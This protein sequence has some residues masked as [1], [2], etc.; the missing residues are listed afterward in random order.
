MI[1]RI[2]Y[3]LVK[4]DNYADANVDGLRGAG[5]DALGWYTYLIAGQDPAQQADILVRVIRAHGGLRQNEFVVCDVEEGS[6]DQSSR[7][8]AY[9]DEVDSGLQM[10]SP[11]GQEWWYSGLNFAI[12]HNLAAARG[13]RWIA[14]YGQSEPAFAHDLW[15]FT[16]AYQF[17]GIAGPSD[18]SVYHGSGQ[19]FLA[20]IGVPSQAPVPT[21]RRRSKPMFVI[22]FNNALH[23][24]NVNAQGNL[25][26]RFSDNPGGGWG[27]QVLA[28]GL[29]PGALVGGEILFG[30]LH[31]LAPTTDGRVSYNWWTQGIG[32]SNQILA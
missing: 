8:N 26:H 4:V 1:A 10:P 12:N 14:A 7:V 24:F 22:A 16:N 20:L 28:S 21:P 32:W 23:E 18:A 27:S 3:G 13:H 29:V 9:L 15:Q 31:I 17:S 30:Q 11:E 6:G 5:A 2:N 19:D 25:V